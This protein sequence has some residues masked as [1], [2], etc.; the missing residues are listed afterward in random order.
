MGYLFTPNHAEQARRGT[1]SSV[2]AKIGDL[3]FSERPARCRSIPLGLIATFAGSH[4]HTGSSAS[5]PAYAPRRR[6]IAHPPIRAGQFSPA[7]FSLLNNILFYH[8][9][10]I[11]M[12]RT[13]THG[14]LEQPGSL[15]TQVEYGKGTTRHACSFFVASTDA[16]LS[17]Q[18][19]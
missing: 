3:Q 16:G 12:Y 13:K 14:Q 7:R 4:P 19:C 2:P 15:S 11:Q 5:N 6:K 18:S 8:I 10:I 1:G 9:N 17:T